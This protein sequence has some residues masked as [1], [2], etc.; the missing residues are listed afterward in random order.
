MFRPSQ[1]SQQLLD[2]KATKQRIIHESTAS[3][4][5][6]LWLTA[7]NRHSW[8]IEDLATGNGKF[9]D[10]YCTAACTV[11]TD[12]LGMVMQHTEGHL[13]PPL[14]AP[15]RS[16]KVPERKSLPEELS[17]SRTNFHQPAG[18]PFPL[19]HRR[20]RGQFVSLRQPAG[21]PGG[22]R[23]LPGRYDDAHTVVATSSH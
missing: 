2:L 20:G 12:G 11:P 22:R 21:N 19:H 5:R 14:P 17:S 15:E 23:A 8:Q 3:V 10:T 18:Q 16:R 4:R 7:G 1:A 13:P 9:T 6:C